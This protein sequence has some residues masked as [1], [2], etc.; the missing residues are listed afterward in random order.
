[1][2]AVAALGTLSISRFS[3]F[4]PVKFLLS[5]VEAMHGPNSDTVT[6][7]PNP[8]MKQAAEFTCTVTR[9]YQ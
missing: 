2:R 8:D 1:M 9:V 7:F 4:A 6:V 3:R 5:W